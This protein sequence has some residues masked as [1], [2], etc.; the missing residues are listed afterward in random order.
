M[1]VPR[2]K[3]LTGAVGS[4]KAKDFNGGFVTS[5][6]QLLQNKV[7]GLEITNNSGQPGVATTIKIQGKQFYPCR[8]Q[9]IVCN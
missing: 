1:A 2:K 4:V 5:P 7:S 9:S 6:D 3:D 8:K